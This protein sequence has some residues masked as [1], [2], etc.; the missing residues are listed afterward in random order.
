MTNIREVW[1]KVVRD[2]DKKAFGIL[3]D[4][5]YPKLFSFSVRY[6]KLPS[7]AEEVVS[8]VFYNILKDRYKLKNIRRIGPY[9]YRAVKNK[10]LS[11][12]RD[13]EKNQTLDSIEQL[14]DYLIDETEEPETFAEDFETMILLD[15]AVGQ[16]PAQRQT[17]YR[18]IRED[19]LY[20]E[21]V[22]ELLSLSHRTVEKHLELAI[23]ELCL[24]LK[25][26]LKDQRQHPRIRKIFPRSF[27]FFFL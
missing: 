12:L 11:W 5:Y 19:G 6:T 18:L 17:V 13:Q 10:S 4:F 2:N 1:E 3:F 25:A 21:E 23:K 22:A 27:L 24:T 9:L 8:D 7:G 26:Y 15:N 16:L 20:I 14:E